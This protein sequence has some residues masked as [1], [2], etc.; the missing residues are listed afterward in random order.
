MSSIQS[1]KSTQYGMEKILSE[2]KNN[3]KVDVTSLNCIGLTDSFQY[4][5]SIKALK[6]K[7]KTLYRNCNA[8]R[9]FRRRSEERPEEEEEEEETAIP[10]CTA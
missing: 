4:R 3:R 5:K 2:N 1:V 9:P 10:S 6:K 8:F 7:Y